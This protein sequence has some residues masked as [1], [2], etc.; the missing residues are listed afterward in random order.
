MTSTKEFLMADMEWG[1]G[2]GEYP[3]A[4]GWGKFL[5]GGEKGTAHETLDSKQLRYEFTQVSL[6]LS[7]FQSKGI[8]MYLAYGKTCLLPCLSL[9][10]ACLRYKWRS[11]QSPLTAS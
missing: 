10:P 11:S 6:H 2:G 4:D 7:T 8:H 9:C 3:R 5:Q 1:G